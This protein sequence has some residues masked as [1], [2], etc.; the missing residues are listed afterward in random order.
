MLLSSIYLAVIQISFITWFV[1]RTIRK[2]S[3]TFIAKKMRLTKIGT[4]FLTFTLV[5]SFTHSAHSV[6]FFVPTMIFCVSSIGLPFLLARRHEN[7]CHKGFLLFLQSIIFEMKSGKSLMSASKTHLLLLPEALRSV[8]V[9]KILDKQSPNTSLKEQISKRLLKLTDDLQEIAGMNSNQLQQIQLFQKQ[10]KLDALL[11]HK[12][13]KALLQTH[14]QCIFLLLL[15]SALTIYS[16]CTYPW[17]E[18]KFFFFVSLVLMALGLLLLL[19]I[20]RSPKWK[21]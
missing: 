8:I 17:S 20:S 9:S 14:I 21:T 3:S 11:R 12:S 4:V 13:R 19:K 5:I 18:F 15:F 1:I 10:L 16:F 2:Y 6:V 7:L